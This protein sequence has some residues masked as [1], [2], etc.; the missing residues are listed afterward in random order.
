MRAATADIPLEE[1][2]D[3]HRTRIWISLQESDAAHDHSRGAIRALECAGVQKRLL[4]GVQMPVF[5][6][7]LDCHN[8]LPRSRAHGNLARSSRRAAD[9]HSAG[10]ALP[11]PAAVFAA[12][13][14]KL[15]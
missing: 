11:F 7:S 13:Q 3:F 15:I 9:Q 14:S 8:G 12:G 6:E 4:D 10:T 2:S 1:L 5:F